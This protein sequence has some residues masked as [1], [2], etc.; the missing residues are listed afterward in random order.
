[1]RSFLDYKAVIFDFDG[2][3]YDNSHIG[4][5][6]I[7]SRPFS[8]F[9][10]KAERDTRRNLKGRDIETPQ[11]FKYEYCKRAAKLLGTSPEIF[12]R[13]YE[14]KYLKYLER[15]LRKKRF[16]ARERIAEVFAAL[17]SSGKKIALYSDYERIQARALAC[18][19]PQEALDLC[20]GFYSPKDFG[21]LKPA[22]RAF[23]QIAADL[24]AR[25]KDCLVVGD[26]DDT[27]GMGARLTEM[28]FVQIKT[29]KPKDVLHF[30]HPIMDWND[31]VDAVLRGEP[32]KA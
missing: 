27:D 12:A 24:S 17:V 6:L 8:F 22:P 5:A 19:V 25:P 31:F 7:L 4:R 21:C 14:E 23:L 32:L 20:S 18:G 15:A 29:K 28:D 3:L 16:K 10:M 9:Y 26:R 13:W 1:M 11:K 2:T 30:S